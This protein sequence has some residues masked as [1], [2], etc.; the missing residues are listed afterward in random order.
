MNDDATVNRIPPG[1]V[2]VLDDIPITFTLEHV[3]GRMRMRAGV[4][5]ARKVAEELL[6]LVKERAVPKAVYRASVAVNDGKKL[7]VDN[8]LMKSYAP[9]L[10]FE[11]PETVFPYV[12]TCGTEIQEVDIPK[13]EILRYYIFNV[14]KELLLFSAIQYLKK[15]LVS[16][17]RLKDLTHIGP[18][19]AFGPIWQQKELFS[20][21][22]NVEELIGVRLSPHYLMLPEKS[23][24]GMLFETSVEIER[25][26]ICPQ[27]KCISRRQAYAPEILTRYR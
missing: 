25:C 17:Y 4:D 16:T 18:G 10:R 9:L 15:Y 7:Y 20:I 21:I 1:I 24:S 19:E 3:I 14:I 6:E 27:V 11:S 5:K 12:A 26:V 8:V 2:E 23:S 13:R 22:G